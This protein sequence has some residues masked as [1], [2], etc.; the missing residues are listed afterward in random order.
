[1]HYDSVR[2]KFTIDLTIIR[3]NYLTLQKICP[4]SEVGASVKANCYG[5][6]IE[7]I[8]P[9]LEDAGC[10]NFFVADRDEGVKLRNI[11]QKIQSNIYVLNGY[12][13]NDE[14][15]FI[16]YN[17]VPTLNS[18]EQLNSWQ[19]YA[20]KKG[21]KLKAVIHFNTGLNRLGVNEDELDNFYNTGL[22][23][24]LVMSHLSCA[25]DLQS[26]ANN[27]QLSKFIKLVAN[28]P[29]S[30]RSLA[31]S[32]AIF[33]GKEY[34]FD[35]VRPGA[36]IYGINPT[37][38]LENCPIKNPL[39]LTAPIISIKQLNKGDYVGYNRTYMAKKDMKIATLP[40]GYADGYPRV[41]SNKGAVFINNNKAEIIGRISM[42]L[43]NIDVSN[44]PENDLFL[45]QEV[46]IISNQ[47]TPD[48]IAKLT[49]TNAYEI[50]TMFD[51][52]RHKI[53]Y[54]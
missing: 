18:K 29:H 5:L 20:H 50:L 23:I 53:N 24:I 2:C 13:P 36:A 49:D 22:D 11:L 35:I 43:V 38:Y 26:P 52:A 6:G 12:F 17:M 39:K 15:I 14:D 21:Q 40:F 31:N 1:M 32:S 16:K 28:F 37:P 27:E 41:L 48:D 45:G 3:N 46:E 30:K 25:E 33:L 10:K 47:I 9:I 8:A 4:T 54:V 42:D 7:K 19:N 44:I 51:G 34:H